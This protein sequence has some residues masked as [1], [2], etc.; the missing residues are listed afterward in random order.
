MSGTEYPGRK[1]ARWAQAVLVAFAVISTMDVAVGQLLIEPIRKEFSLGDAQTGMANVTVA[2]ALYA[3]FAVPA[4]LLADRSSRSFLLVIASTFWVGALGCMAL[5]QGLVMFMVGKAMLGTAM[6]LMYPASL[7]LL[8]DLFPPEHR[9]SATASYSI[10]QLM[11]SAAGVLVGGLLFAK[12]VEMEKADPGAIFGLEP[13]RGIF[14]FYCIVSALLIP[15]TL[16]LKEPVRQELSEAGGGTFKELWGYRAFLVPLFLGIMFLNGTN[17]VG[18][19]LFPALTRIYHLEPGEFA[20]WMSALGL[21]AGFAGLI[22]SIRLVEFGRRRGSSGAIIAPAVP[23]ALLCGVGSLL[24]TMPSIYLF[25]ALA[26]VFTIASA[27][28]ISLPVLAVNFVVPNNLRGLSMGIY[29]VLVAL[30]SGV[31]API[32]GWLGEQLGGELMIGWAMAIAG[33]AFSLLTALCYAVA[34]KNAKS[35]AS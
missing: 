12:F 26:A 2:Y 6:A 33:V 4:G 30:A 21:F 1:Q 24:A 32:V 27:V 11:G 35:L 16:S 18:V 10:G 7:S 20:P 5:S 3:L 25:A 31:S 14:L 17:G 9:A 15:A 22:I 23:A 28:A 13:W 29:V 34:A 19:W 8:S